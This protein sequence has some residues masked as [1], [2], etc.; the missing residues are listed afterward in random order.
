M[1]QCVCAKKKPKKYAPT[2]HVL[3]IKCSNVYNGESKSKKKYFSVSW[4]C[5]TSCLQGDWCLVLISKEFERAQILDLMMY[6]MYLIASSIIIEYT[7]CFKERL[8]LLPWSQW[9]AIQ[10]LILLFA[11]FVY[12]YQL[13]WIKP[14]E[15]FMV[16]FVV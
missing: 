2:V 6:E 5:F 10:T 16:L 1:F 14:E 12:C 11:I 8:R 9:T 7:Q 3:R 13:Y 15:D 4:K